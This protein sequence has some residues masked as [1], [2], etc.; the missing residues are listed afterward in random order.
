MRIE[1][2][3]AQ[4]K[5]EILRLYKAQIGREFCPWTE[6]YPDGETIDFDL[7]RDSLFV[8]KDGDRILMAEGCTH[9]RQCGDIGTVK[10]PNWLRKYSGKGISIETCSGKDFP[11]DL[12]GFSAVIHCGGCMNTE[13]EMRY[14]MR[15][16]EDQQVPFT[17]YGIVIAKMTG[18]L[19]R[20]IRIF[21]E[22]HSLVEYT[23]G[24]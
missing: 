4:D 10:I 15:C 22:I 23:G 6:D 11:E 8:L 19:E 5:E 16:A 18:I 24:K 20:S 7:S 2:A 9:H 1:A 13:R 17:N 3:K 12:S 14:R 21:P